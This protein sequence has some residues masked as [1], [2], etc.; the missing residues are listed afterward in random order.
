MTVI[1][2]T[3][4][5]AMFAVLALAASV[6]G[7]VMAETYPSKPITMI[8]PF[9]AGGPTD[10]VA[11]LMAESMSRHLGQ[12]VV[13]ENVAGAGGTAGTERMVR[14]APDGYTVLLHHSGITAAPALYSNL[15]FD[16][17]AIETAGAINTGP[18]VLLGKKQLEPQTAAEFFEYL[19]KNADKV[20][21]GHAGVG[22]NAHVCG[23]MLQAFLGVKLAFVA[24]RG[25]GPAMN[26]LVAGQ[27]DA[28]CDQSTNAVPQITGGTI[29]PYLVLDDQ[30]IAS[31]KDVPNSVEAGFNDL[32]MTIW[33]GL[34]APPGTPKEIIAKLNEALKKALTEKSITDKF[35]A[36]GTSAYPPDEQ[37]PEAH[38]KRFLANIEMNAK[39][40][41]AAG[42]KAQEAK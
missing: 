35:E 2:P 33:H 32:Q 5:R 31:I 41:G 18:M 15:R 40:L 42:V 27:I 14:A 34:Y 19:K 23:L 7:P 39:V 29:K 24:Y 6:A 4:R 30:R 9:A 1:R 16:T 13:V 25:T 38:R 28:M 12:Q 3:R 37:T 36:V 22:S 10:A 11:R 17:K 20:T 26:D 8:V 21:L